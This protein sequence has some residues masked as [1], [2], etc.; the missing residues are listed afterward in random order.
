MTKSIIL[1]TETTGLK[2][3]RPVEIAWVDINNHDNRFASFFNPGIP[4]E[5]GAMA[6]HHITDE[7]VA[8]CPPH[9]DFKLPDGLQ[10]LIGHNI[11]FDMEVIQTCGE[12][13][14]VKTICTLAMSRYLYPETDSHKLTAMLYML[15]RE[16][17]IAHAQSAHGAAADVDM[18]LHLFGLLLEK[19]RADGHGLKTLDDLWQ[20]SEMARIPTTI[21]FGKH[22]GS[23]L[24]DLPADYV[25]WLLR[26]D[27]IDPYLR[28]ALTQ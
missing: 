23:R 9:T 5:Y 14:P 3:C 11:D 21:T 27:D 10:Y 18:T 12:M 17:A 26:Q 7:R 15:D 1:D 6:T 2:D 19:A 4:I 8:K 13:P 24:E 25:K 16:Y 20:F 28:K 22:K